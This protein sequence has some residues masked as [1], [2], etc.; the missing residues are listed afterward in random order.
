MAEGDSWN[1][2]IGT[3]QTD[4]QPSAGVEEQVSFFIKPGAAGPFAMYDGTT[5]TQFIADA[6]V[7]SSEAKDAGRYDLANLLV[8]IDN[9]NYIRKQG[10]DQRNAM[11][12]LQVG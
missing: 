9:S 7:T 8:I 2:F 5:A 12:G 1:Q 4:R 11:G 3:A 10:T 6:V